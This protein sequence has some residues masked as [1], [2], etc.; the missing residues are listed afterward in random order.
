M[1]VLFT[2]NAATTLASSITNS[3]TSITVASSTGNIFPSPTGSDYFLVTLQG[4]SGTPI[5]I[6]KCTARSGDTLTVVRAQE[7]TT[8]SAF[9]GGDKVE[10]RI[11][12]GEMTNLVGGSARGGGTDQVFFENGQTVNYNYTITTNKNAVSAG[13]VTIATSITVTVPTSSRWVIV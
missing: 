2:N 1:A 11:T 10:L 6:V 12:A 13:P 5:E 9:T 7:G 8:A 3:A 4:V